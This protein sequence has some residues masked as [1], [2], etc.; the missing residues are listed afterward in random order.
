[1]ADGA[2]RLRVEGRVQGVGFRWYV[3]EAARRLGL[4]GTV[5]NLPDG[6]VEIDAAG[7]ADA[8]SALERAAREG[9]PGAAVADVHLTPLAGDQPLPSP[10]QVVR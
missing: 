4:A 10:F 9:P 6:A 7:A 2:V 3:R 8:I 1:M 5:R